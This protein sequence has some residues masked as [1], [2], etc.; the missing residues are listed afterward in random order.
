MSKKLIEEII[1]DVEVFETK[2]N[3]N[4]N[5]EMFKD[6]GEVV[7]KLV[8]LIKNKENKRKINA[9]HYEVYEELA[10]C[11]KL[12]VEEKET[13][14][15][16]FKGIGMKYDAIGIEDNDIEESI[17]FLYRD[18]VKDINN[19]SEVARFLLKANKTYE[20]KESSGKGYY[21]ELIEI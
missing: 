16:E 18:G 20:V 6:L 4:L 21:P 3:E 11:L 7:E 13:P 12:S 15:L 8:S 17:I 10:K 19:G 9:N 1:T 2:W 5:T 14:E